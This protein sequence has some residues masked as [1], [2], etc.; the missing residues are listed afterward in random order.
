[1]VRARFG[2]IVEVLYLLAQDTG[3][4]RAVPK[5]SLSPSIAV[6]P[7]AISNQ[8]VVLRLVEDGRLLL[9]LQLGVVRIRRLETV[10]VLGNRMVPSALSVAHDRLK[11]L[12][13]RVHDVG[14]LVRVPSFVID[15]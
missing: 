5:V 4:E 9:F 2:P 12:F 7:I 8:L 10:A 3:L 6:V 13:L 14:Q 11:L 15:G 1:M